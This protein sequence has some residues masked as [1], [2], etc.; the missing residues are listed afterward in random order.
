MIEV[1]TGTIGTIY[2]TTYKDGVPT[3]PGSTPTVVVTDA[4]T[5]STVVTG[6]SSLIDADYE[7]EYSFELPSSATMV[8]RVLKVVWH[9]T[10]TGKTVE[11]TEYVYVV[12][13]YATIDEIVD[14]LGFSSRPEDP[15]YFPYNKIRSAERAARMVIDNEL[16]FSFKKQAGSIVAYGAGSDVLVLPEHI[17]SVSSLQENGELVI[18]NSI[19]LNTFGYDVEI[20]ETGYG[21]RIVPANSGDDIGEQEN[22]DYSTGYSIGRFREGFRYEVSGFIGWNYIPSEIKQCMFLLVND[23]LCND[24]IWRSRY[25]K[26]INSGQM[27]VEISS[28]AFNGT[29]NAIVDS[30]LQEFKMIQAVII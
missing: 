3:Q 20:T 26:K 8:D 28:L 27:S 14:E 5:G 23:L 9:Y 25:V 2:L 22:Y 24:S 30:I 6:T 15:N 18:D 12:T 13:P 11:E 21:I 19:D 17:I 29:G 4:A 10:M 16:G 1:Y 7:G